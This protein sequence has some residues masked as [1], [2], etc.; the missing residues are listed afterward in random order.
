[1]ATAIIIIA[2]IVIVIFSVKS[3]MKKLSSGCCG[4]GGDTVKK[5]KPSDSNINS[6]PCLKRAH[7]GGMTCKNCAIRVENA[8]NSREGFMAKVDFSKKTA[9]I[10]MK[11]PADSS[12]IEDIVRRAGYDVSSIETIK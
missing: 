10:Y 11:N 2:L 3:Y 4:A 9:D 5:I 8:F 6:Y 7:I 1:M 12:I